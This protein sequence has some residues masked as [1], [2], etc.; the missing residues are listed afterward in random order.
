MFGKVSYIFAASLFLKMPIQY[1]QPNCN[2]HTCYVK[3]VHFVST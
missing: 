2:N 3:V 1:Q